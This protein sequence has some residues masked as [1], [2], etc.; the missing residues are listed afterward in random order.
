MRQ[1][2]AAG[3]WHLVFFSL[4]LGACASAGHRSARSS[5]AQSMDSAS[6]ACR[7]SPLYCAAVAGKE[8]AAT[9][10]TGAQAAQAG[11]SLAGALTLFE[12]AQRE[13]VEQ[14]LKTCVEQA[15]AEVNL[16]RFG[17][18][19]TKAQCAE[20]VGVNSKGQ[21]ETQ[22][23][24][25]GKEKHKLALQ[26]IQEHLSR[27][28]PG[29][30]SLEQRYRYDLESNKTTLVSEKEARMLLRQNRS[31]ELR[32]TIRPDV[33]I[34]SGDPLRAHVVYDLKFQCPS[35]NQ[36]DW[37]D[38]EEMG[39]PYYGSSQGDIYGE[40]LGGSVAIVAPIWGIIW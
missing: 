19:P 36:P 31:G 26:C 27:E 6:S 28:W 34:H 20:Q 18:S 5:Y 17:G 16:R 8:P 10:A 7:Q 24:R 23:M 25:L 14:V 39:H 21:P 35:S 4:F 38:Y 9:A 1:H 15:H 37:R 3:S 2:C 29:G 13:R 22:A 33:V 12:D 40:A 30:F 11:A 32:N